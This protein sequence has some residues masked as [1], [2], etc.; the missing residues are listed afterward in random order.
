VAYPTEGVFGLGCDP[1]NRDAVHRLLRLK[2]RPVAQGLILIAA[3]IG[4]LLPLIKP[5]LTPAMLEAFNRWPAPR[6]VLFPP[7]EL[8]PPWILGQH[9]TVA[10]RVTAHPLANRVCRL[11]GQ[12]LVSTSANRRG[13]PAA[14]EAEA[15][16]ACF[17]DKIDAI[18]PGQVLTPGQ[19]SQITDLA[20]N[21]LRQ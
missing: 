10:L 9:S 20:G 11:F 12:P 8:P 6:T 14:V 3:G 1:Y 5:P 15:V 16:S 7:S 17:G 4:D 19:P 2:N 21:T 18:V 13:Q